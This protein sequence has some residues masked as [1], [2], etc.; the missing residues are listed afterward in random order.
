VR[1]PEAV[2][3]VAGSPDG[4]QD[5]LGRHII[6]ESRRLGRLVCAPPHIDAGG[7]RAHHERLAGTEHNG[8]LPGR[9]LEASQLAAATRDPQRQVMAAQLVAQASGRDLLV[10][11]SAREDRADGLGAKLLRAAHHALAL[12]A[13]FGHQ[14]A[15]DQVDVVEHE[16]RATLLGGH[17]LLRIGDPVVQRLRPSIPEPGV[18]EPVGPQQRDQRDA[19][20]HEA[21]RPL[22]RL[23]G[24]HERV[25]SRTG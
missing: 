17:Q 10:H 1:A 4:D 14:H 16:R 20:A 3:A 6:G 2:E 5:L 22:G 23:R 24:K 21:T 15:G 8:D 12:G 25:G 19:A 9:A 18:P 11:R 7:A 13:V